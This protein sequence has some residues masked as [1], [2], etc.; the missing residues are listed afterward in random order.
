MKTNIVRIETDDT[1]KTY[2]L[3]NAEAPQLWA[4]KMQITCVGDSGS[5]SFGCTSPDHTLYLERATL[6]AA[7]LLPQTKT[8]P[9]TI[10]ETPIDLAL[11]FLEKLGIY[12]TE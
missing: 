8:T 3:P 2:D 1:H 6:V 10:E 5:V 9:V 4:L 12:P 7:G 11:R